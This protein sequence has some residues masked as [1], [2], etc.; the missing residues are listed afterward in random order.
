MATWW[1]GWRSRLTLLASALLVPLLVAGAF[2]WTGWQ[3]SDRLHHSTGVV[4]NLDQMVT[5]K[6]HNYSLGNQLGAQLVGLSGSQYDWDFGVTPSQAQTGL[7]SGRYSV[8]VVIPRNFSRALLSDGSERGVLAIQT[9]PLA[10]VD[11]KVLAGTLAEAAQRGL[12]RQ[13]GVQALSGIYVTFD[14]VDKDLVVASNKAAGAASSAVS[15]NT[16]AGTATRQA[17]AVKQ[18]TQQVANGSQNVAKQANQANQSAQTA[19]RSGTQGASAAN[20]AA[21][22]AQQ[23]QT[24]AG[25]AAAGAGGLGSTISTAG[26]GADTAASQ[27]SRAGTSAAGL[28]DDNSAISTAAT[29]AQGS[30]TK[31]QDAVNAAVKQQKALSAELAGLSGTAAAYTKDVSAFRAAVQKWTTTVTI[32]ASTTPGTLD[33]STVQQRLD[34]VNADVKALQ[35]KSVDLTAAATALASLDKVN[36]WAAGSGS[37]TK[38]DKAVADTYDTDYFARII[39]GHGTGSGELAAAQAECVSHATHDVNGTQVAVNAPYRNVLWDNIRQADGSSDEATVCADYVHVGAG[40]EQSLGKLQ[41]QKSQTTAVPDAMK[42]AMRTA[43]SGR[44][45]AAA[46]DDEQFLPVYST[47]LYVLLHR[48]SEPYYT[49]FSA[50]YAGARTDARA[51]LGNPDIATASQSIDQAQAVLA[52]LDPKT[53]NADMKQLQT[54]V[55]GLAITPGT[56]TPARTVSIDGSQVLQSAKDADASVQNDQKTLAAALATAV[57]TDAGNQKALAAL[58]TS[59]DADTLQ[60]QLAA[61]LKANASEADQIKNLTTQV[62]AVQGGLRTLTASL[63]TAQTQAQQ[64]AQQTASTSSGAA[65][66]AGRITALQTALKSA[67]GAGAGTA[68]Q[69]A[70]VAQGAQQLTKSA[71]GAAQ[72]AAGLSNT[73][74]KV[75]QQSKDVSNRAQDTATTVKGTSTTVSNQ[76]AQQP[77]TSAHPLTTATTDQARH[78]NIAWWTPLATMA[79][80]LGAMTMYMLFRPISQATRGSGAGPMALVAEVL[81]PGVVIGAVQAFIM[82][83]ASARVMHLGVADTVK[84]LGVLLLMAAA[85]MA[86]NFVLVAVFGA[87]GRVLAVVF[88][89]ITGVGVVTNALP[90]VFDTIRGISPLSPALDAVRSIAAGAPGT[91]TAVGHLLLWTAGSI[92]LA[93]LL[94]LRA[95]VAEAPRV[96]TALG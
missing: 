95:R 68:A 35:Q 93:G 73:V 57:A 40:L 27:A 69:T 30:A 19:T 32:P 65:A 70:Q 90:E 64:V 80:W 17:G 3:S 14:Q 71:S 44:L 36:T 53:L 91:G 4:V 5:S 86:V 61:V 79:M 63:A 42:A 56:T 25:A 33:K 15:L 38:P 72:A 9:S 11:Q 92:A 78:P 1:S 81:A 34:A 76:A 43:P 58:G 13:L 60:Q 94:I 77:S 83:L 47:L 46:N 12:A 37:T 24:Q 20:Q 31:Y 39:A 67:S 96:A 49:G 85:F 22:D 54:A 48:G 6:G 87:I 52:A 74:T 26:S 16:L 45:T 10:T 21:S 82:A 2:V 28:S 7:A 89:L 50:G 75:G 59:T 29:G 8:A 88:A 66:L 18:Q 41:G 84:T 55:T 23:H 51:A 62:A